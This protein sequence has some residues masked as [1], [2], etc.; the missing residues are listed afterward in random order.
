[1]TRAEMAAQLGIRLASVLAKVGLAAADVSGALKEPID[2]ALRSMGYAED[3]LATAA[4]DD[5]VGFL[6][7]ARY[8]TLRHVRD[9][10]ATQFDAS[11]PGG[12]SGRR[13]QVFAQVTILVEAAEGDVIRLFGSVDAPAADGGL[14][15]MDLNF[16]ADC[17]EEQFA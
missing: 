6:A 15:T 16:L 14:V 2:D 17:R 1:M 10:L 3:E 13:S 11:L 4:P 5:A 8:Q 7:M 12:L 9:A